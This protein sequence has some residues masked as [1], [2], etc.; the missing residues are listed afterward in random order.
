MAIKTV[1]EGSGDESGEGL[2]FKV[3]VELIMTLFTDIDKALNNVKDAN[4][5]KS[6]LE[7]ESEQIKE[8]DGK[9]DEEMKKSWEELTQI[10]KLQFNNTD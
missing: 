5:S 7:E 8:R 2:D 10:R 1:S 3:E 4:S 9:K 6:N